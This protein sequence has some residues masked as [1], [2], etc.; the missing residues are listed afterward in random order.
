M[1]ET[2]PPYRGPSPPIIDSP[3][4]RTQPGSP[5]QRS[6]AINGVVL[7]EIQM[8]QLD[9]MCR[10]SVPSGAYW[11]DKISGACGFI[12]GPCSGFI[13][14]GLE[15]GGPLRSD[16][17]NG[18]TGVFINGRQL[19]AVDV[20]GLQQFVAVM[21]GRY[22]VDAMGTFGYEGGPALGNLMQMA[23]ARG[24]GESNGGDNFWSSRFAA[25]NYDSSSGSG[26]VSVPGHGPIGFGP[27]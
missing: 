10:M 2:P 5:G 22:W 17:S 21:P 4:P 25:G 12:G 3:A 16:C 19:H 13:Q 27:D 1:A 15:L 8:T 20:L 26:Y 23:Q 6:I 24:R 9:Q 18:H 7:S 11:Y 14:A